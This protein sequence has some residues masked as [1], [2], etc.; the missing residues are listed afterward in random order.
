MTLSEN[1][2]SNIAGGM[3]NSSEAVRQ[4]RSVLRVKTDEIKSLRRQLEDAQTNANELKKKLTA[5]ED[6]RRQT[7]RALLDA[8]SSAGE[9]LAFEWITWDRLAE[10]NCSVAMLEEEISL[11]EAL[12]SLIWPYIT[13]INYRLKEFFLYG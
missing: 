6:S 5:A 7:D 2:Y 9:M 11:N 4:V 10:V 8:K 13:S 1:D 3:V 12:L